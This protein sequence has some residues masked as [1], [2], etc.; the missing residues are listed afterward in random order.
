MSIRAFVVTNQ[1]GKRKPIANGTL[2]PWLD[3][4]KMEFRL[5]NPEPGV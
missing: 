5:G 4:P 1:A 2:A 3:V